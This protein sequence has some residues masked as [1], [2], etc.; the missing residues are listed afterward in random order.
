MA[1]TEQLQIRVSPA[2][3]SLIRTRAIQAGMGMSDWVLL[4]LF[5]P[6]DVRFR[7]CVEALAEDPD[8][9]SFTLAALHD[10]LAG[11]SG[12]QI[13][14]GLRNPPGV[15]LPPFEAN[16]VAAMIEFAAMTQGV[17]SPEW[18]GRVPPL[19]RPWFGTDLV[20]LRLHLLTQSPAVFRRR[21]IFIDTSVGG[22]V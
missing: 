8:R 4:Q 3:K 13:T 14:H 17:P 20:S 5:P 19:D 10:L 16:Y 6:V 2:E 9:R 15:S 12:R 1:K 11:L 22:R 21:N 18:T 7:E